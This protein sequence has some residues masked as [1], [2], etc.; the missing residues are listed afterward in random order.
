MATKELSLQRVAQTTGQQVLFLLS[1]G[2]VGAFLYWWYQAWQVVM[3]PIGAA[4]ASLLSA[5]GIFTL[6]LSVVYA[7]VVPLF[8][9]MLL[10]NSPTGAYL[11]KQTW[12]YP[13]QLAV[14][15]FALVLTAFGGQTMWSWLQTAAPTVFQTGMQI[16]AF[17]A[18]LV[19]S[20]FVPSMQFAYQSPGQQ[21]LI[22]QQAHEIKKLRK[23]HDGEIA[24]IEGRMIRAAVLASMA[25]TDMLPKDHEEAYKTIRGLHMGIADSLRRVA[26]LQSVP[27]DVQRALGIAEDAEIVEKMEQVQAWLEGPAD[28]IEQAYA[29]VEYRDLP[30]APAVAPSDTPLAQ[31][32]RKII[33]GSHQNAAPAIPA[34][35]PRSAGEIPPPRPAA[36]RR[37]ARRYAAEYEAMR[38]FAH[39]SGGGV[40]GVGDLAV[41]IDKADRSARERIAAWMQEGLVARDPDSKNAY[42]FTESDGAA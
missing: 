38:A 9:S 6:V 32:E 39:R 33:R 16:P 35:P 25:W 36:Q 7:V 2:F 42:Y 31:L 5:L 26:S 22:I 10:P 14:L 37:E 28:H 41:V 34:S 40:W 3:T 21:M 29:Y 23:L 1:F 12:A 19:G 15:V 4:P 13:G 17:V 20:V 18:A 11:Q 30:D 8:W 27:A 24:V